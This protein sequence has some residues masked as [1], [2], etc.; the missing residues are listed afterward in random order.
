[1]TGQP[2][3]KEPLGENILR[4]YSR[5]TLVC[6]TRGQPSF[7]TYLIKKLPHRLVQVH[8]RPSLW[9]YLGIGPLAIRGL[10]LKFLLSS[11]GFGP[12]GHA[13]ENFNVVAHTSGQ[14]QASL[15]VTLTIKAGAAHGLLA[16]VGAGI[17][18]YCHAILYNS[19]LAPNSFCAAKTDLDE[20]STQARLRIDPKP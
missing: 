10:F 7:D 9:W 3:S 17:L 20:L 12:G 14:W 13:A 4:P 16:R 11:D 2:S 18:D 5:P 6:L 19:F 8:D 15:L 1:M